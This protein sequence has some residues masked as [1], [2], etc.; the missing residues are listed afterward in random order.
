MPATR[1]AEPQPLLATVT[2]SF[3]HSSLLTTPL[4]PD[5]LPLSSIADEA[6]SSFGEPVRQKFCVAV[7]PL[8]TL[9]FAED[10]GAQEA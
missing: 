6:Y 5:P 3:T 4:L 2:V 7:P 10:D 9:T 8:L 1:V